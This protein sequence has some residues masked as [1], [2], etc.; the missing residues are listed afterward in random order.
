MVYVARGSSDGAWA[1]AS[2]APRN[3]VD[4]VNH[5]AIR[6]GGVVLDVDDNEVWLRFVHEYAIPGEQIRTFSVLTPRGHHLYFEHTGGKGCIRDAA[7][8][9]GFQPKEGESG[10]TFD[11]IPWRRW[12][13]WSLRPQSWGVEVMRPVFVRYWKWGPLVVRLG[14]YARK[15]DEY[16]P[17]M[18]DGGENMQRNN[19]GPDE[20]ERDRQQC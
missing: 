5:A 19:R 15:A 3:V 20:G 7:Y 16:P 10:A 14:F 8:R 17:S 11:L 9:Q 13:A 4:K 12:R 1:R 6:A 18:N 2:T